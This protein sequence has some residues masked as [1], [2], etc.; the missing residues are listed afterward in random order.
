MSNLKRS[1]A[2]FTAEIE[3]GVMVAGMVLAVTVRLPESVGSVESV[4]RSWPFTGAELQLMTWIL[5]VD[6]GNIAM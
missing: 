1:V 2:L 5:A 4:L 3:V 6:A